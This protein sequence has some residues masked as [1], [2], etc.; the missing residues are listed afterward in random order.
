MVLALFNL[1]PQSCKVA[2]WNHLLL[3]LSC[4]FRF[5][6]KMLPQVCSRLMKAWLKPPSG[7][8][9][10]YCLLVNADKTKLLVMGNCQVLQRLPKDFHV[11]LPGKEVTPTQ[12]EI[13]ACNGSNVKIW[14]TCFTLFH[15]VLHVC[16]INTIKSLFDSVFREC[17]ALF[18]IQ[19]IILLFR[20]VWH[21]KEEHLQTAKCPE[22]CCKS[23]L[24]QVQENLNS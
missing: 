11:T 6:S 18:D 21:I 1:Y 14:W 13:L 15:L 20:M 2:H 16:Q 4:I 3:T 5:L 12:R 8:S 9:Y 19:L 22:F 7:V 10:N 24:S 23:W 17:Y